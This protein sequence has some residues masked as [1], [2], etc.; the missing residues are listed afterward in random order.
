LGGAALAGS[1][2]EFRKHIAEE[3]DR[4]GKVVKFAN[5]KPE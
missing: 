5:L 1:P 2:A 4:W 3:T